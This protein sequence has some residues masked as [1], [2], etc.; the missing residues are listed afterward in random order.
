[1]AFPKAPLYQ[2]LEQYSK[3]EGECLI[4]QSPPRKD[5]YGQIWGDPPK[6]G[7]AR[8]RNLG[9]HRAAYEVW[10]GPI[11]KGMLVLHSCD[12]R[13]CI[14]PKHL[15]LGTHADNMAQ[16]VARGRQDQVSSK[17]RLEN[18]LLRAERDLLWEAFLAH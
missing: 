9:A 3:W 10:V 6:T 11:P 2:R 4:W 7:S 13:L 18:I 15:S 1:M 5:G 17:L 14:N 8:A 16:M 12:N